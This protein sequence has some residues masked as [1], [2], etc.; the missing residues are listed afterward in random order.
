MAGHDATLA[1]VTIPPGEAVGLMVPSAN[2]D[3]TVWG[4]R[5][6]EFDLRRTKHANAAFGFG[7]HFCVGH[8]LARIQM[9]TGLR[10]LLERFPRLQLDPE[11]PP[12]FR[13]WDIAAPRRSRCVGDSRDMRAAC[14]QRETSPRLDRSG[15]PGTPPPPDGGNRP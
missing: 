4:E 2:R 12:V 3:E 1:G 6:D 15:G 9:R 13:G 10:L 11:R 14:S 7:P 8:Q 5:A